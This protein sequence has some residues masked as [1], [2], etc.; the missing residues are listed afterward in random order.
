[1]VE[2]KSKYLRGVKKIILKLDSIF[3]KNKWTSFLDLFRNMFII[4]LAGFFSNT[5]GA[6]SFNIT[7]P[8][9]IVQGVILYVVVLCFCSAYH[10]I[11]SAKKGYF[12]IY[13]SLLFGIIL[14]LSIIT[15][16][17]MMLFYIGII[18]NVWALVYERNKNK[19]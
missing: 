18:S 4:L 2:S 15:Y 11:K 7:H 1:M 10:I 14:E 17:S 19:I 6:N 9:L 3:E 16:A 5:I 12:V 8:E 13:F